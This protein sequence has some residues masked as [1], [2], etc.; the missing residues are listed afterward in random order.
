[1]FGLYIHIYS[2]YLSMDSSSECGTKL[3]FSND[4]LLLKLYL[5]QLLKSKRRI[6]LLRRLLIANGPLRIIVPDCL[7]RKF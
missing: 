7:K 2:R 3:D 6:L 1:M 5:I 4:L